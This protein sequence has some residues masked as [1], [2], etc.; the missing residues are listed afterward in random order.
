MNN[1]IRRYIVVFASLLFLTV[2]TVT[3]SSLHLKLVWAIVIALTIAV[4]KGGL[5]ASYFMHLINEKEVIFALL[6]LTAIL[7]TAI[8]TLPVGEFFNQY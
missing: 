4:L 8:L 5:V 1:E 2:L 6:A 7:L 3:L